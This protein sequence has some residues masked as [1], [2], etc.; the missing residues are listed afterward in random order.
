MRKLSFAAAALVSLALAGSLAAQTGNDTWEPNNN[1]AAALA[2]TFP[3]VGSNS[4][5][6]VIGLSASGH[7][8]YED[9]VIANGDHDWFTITAPTAATGCTVYLNQTGSAAFL[10]SMAITDN[11]GTTV[12]SGPTGGS[13]YT[14]LSA[15]SGD[16]YDGA[17]AV[18]TVTGGTSYKIHVWYGGTTPQPSAITIPYSLSVEYTT[19]DSAEGNHGNNFWG[20]SPGASQTTSPA[21]AT[22][23]ATG[24]PGKT[25]TATWNGWD[26]YMVKLTSPAKITVLMDNLTPLTY[27]V[28]TTP[29]PYTVNFDLYWISS[30]NGGALSTGTTPTSPVPGAT[31]SWPN[32]F[33]TPAAVTAPN[34]SETITTPLLV[35]GTYYFQVQTWITPTGGGVAIVP[36]AGGYT[37]N[38]QTTAGM[39][40]ALEGTSPNENDLPDTAA[41]LA[42]G[43][44]SALKLLYDPSGAEADWYKIQVNDGQN[45]EIEMTITDAANDNLQLMLYKPAPSGSP[46]GD[47][48]DLID[49]SAINNPD[50]LKEKGISTPV[51][52]PREIVGTWGA[53]GAAGT[54]GYPAGEYLLRVSA[55]NLLPGGGVYSLTVTVAG[56]RVVA[57]EDA[58]EPNDNFTEAS[59][60][61]NNNCRIAGG[62][63][64][65]L[66]AMDF[67]DE[68]KITVN[69]GANIEVTLIYDA[70]AK[71]DLDLI[72]VDLDGYGILNQSRTV[73][74]TANSKVVLTG[75]AG[76]SYT[77]TTPPP[78]SGE[79]YIAVQRWASRGA[80][81]SLNVNVNGNNP[82]STLE[83]TSI[84]MNPASINVSS[85]TTQA[86]VQVT[87]NSTTTAATLATLA[88]KLT[89]STGAD[90]TSEYTI[91]G[92]TPT[93]PQAINPSSSQPFVFTITPNT[94]PA[95]PTNGNVIVSAS[96]TQTG[97]A[98]ILGANI[99]GT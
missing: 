48:T 52:T 47:A 40:D 78:S 68:Y 55:G 11:A 7:R 32:G 63:T 95:L 4:W 94:T 16:P 82:L 24:S 66:K 77:G 99:T 26:F 64:T 91:S 5:Y 60:P 13:G 61:T 93:L 50:S 71:T 62:L 8:S 86:T 21:D 96:G 35:P 85:Q 41:T 36:A 34:T 76:A 87:N 53:V 57:P 90:V 23:S 54:T 67:I 97:G 25:F 80:K 49:I 89:L 45:L 37:I 14:P 44:T 92:P 28:G 31:D 58:M 33:S 73:E 43:T 39:D 18:F 84:T 88:L 29:T 70:D 59:D 27:N 19:Y 38:F 6:G 15:G 83:I 65:D 10:V 69:N 42:T 98:K 9:L 74:T 75:T 56:T 30:L 46:K 22:P 81:Y 2:W 3:H 51:V 17:R 20:Y 1:A 79:F 12:I 72:L